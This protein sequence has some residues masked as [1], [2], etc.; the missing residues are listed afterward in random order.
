[1]EPFLSSGVEGFGVGPWCDPQDLPALLL[2]VDG[3]MKL[4]CPGEPVRKG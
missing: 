4:Q 1:M 2:G 3:L